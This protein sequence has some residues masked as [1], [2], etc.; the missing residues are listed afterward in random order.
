M[1]YKYSYKY[2]QRTLGALAVCNTGVQRCEGSYSWGPGV[3]DHYLIHYV[4]SGKGSYRAGGRTFALS[5]GDLFLTCPDESIFYQAD[6][7]DPW[8]Y[9]WVGFHGT[10]AKLLLDQ[11]DLSEETP[12]LRGVSPDAYKQM[13]RIYESRGSLP[14]Q[15]AFMT[16]ALYQLLAALMRDRR[17][18]AARRGD[19]SVQQACEFIGNNLAMPITVEDIAAHV[20]LSRSRLYRLFM[21]E[22]RLSPVQ[23]LTQVRIRQAC[24]LLRRGDLS[25][26]AVAA[27][28]GYENQLYFSRRFREVMGCSPTEFAG[29]I[30]I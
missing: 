8:E 5:A 20:G 12:V 15:A 6:P 27:S 25:V 30:V 2:P 24:A 22:L 14:H 16:G 26:K 11:T 1:E 7:R 10:E 28:V 4:I 9:C 3:R 18:P 13:M 29:N 21:A 17:T 23:V 19:D